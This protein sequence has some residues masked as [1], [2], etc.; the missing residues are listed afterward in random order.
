MVDDQILGEQDVPA[1]AAVIGWH[2]RLALVVL[3]VMPVTTADQTLRAAA[4]RP[5]AAVGARALGEVWPSEAYRVEWEEAHVPQ[6]AAANL[7]LAVPV[8]LRNGGNRVWPASLVFISYHWFRDDTLIVWD[9]VRTRLPRDVRAGGRASL[10]VRVKTPAEP[11]AYVLHLT[12][13]HENVSWFENKGANTFSRPIVVGTTT[14]SVDCG[15]DSTS[16]TA[17]P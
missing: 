7:T 8:T 16:C 1:G 12:L 17:T 9:G 13:V 5:A 6:E 2:V 3:M 14:A 10:A 15:S 4:D 11:G